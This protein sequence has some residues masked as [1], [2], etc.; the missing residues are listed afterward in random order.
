MR[1]FSALLGICF[2]GILQ[3]FATPAHAGDVINCEVSPT[4]KI[5]FLGHRSPVEKLSLGKYEKRHSGRVADSFAYAFGFSVI[6]ESGQMIGPQYEM[7]FHD[8]EPRC[9]L[10]L[11]V[12]DKIF[13]LAARTVYRFTDEEGQRGG[14]VLVMSEDGGKTFSQNLFPTAR[15]PQRDASEFETHRQAV[16]DF[17]YHRGRIHYVE[18]VLSLELTDPLNYQQFLYFESHDLGR[19]WQRSEVSDIPR[20][21][22]KAE[23]EKW[24]E[25]FANDRYSMMRF[26]AASETCKGGY[27]TQCAKQLEEAWDQAIKPCVAQANWQICVKNFVPPV[28]KDL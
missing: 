16:T 25:M 22:T 10:T 20:V 26:K 24:R 4:R 17:G 13:Y 5:R 7:F 8:E 23:V 1:F 9:N 6:D 3:L 11:M 28:L 19:H 27:V 15:H 12:D 21:Y 2:V 14:D 18:G